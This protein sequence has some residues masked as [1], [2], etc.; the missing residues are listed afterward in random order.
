V[1]AIDTN[2]LVRLITLDDQ[3]QAETALKM[4]SENQVFVSHLALME[5][6]WVLRTFH[7]YGRPETLKVIRELIGSEN[8]HVELEELTLWALD[9]AEAGADLADMLLVIAARDHE[10]F[11]TFDKKIAKRA[12][13]ETPVH[14]ELLS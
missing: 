6:A 2:V 5:T 13:S 11:A 7:E 8:I 4:V 3:K 1:I 10:A 9:R 12:G 14:I